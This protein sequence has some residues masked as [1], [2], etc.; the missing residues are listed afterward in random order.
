MSQ[1]ADKPTREQI[2][3]EPAGPR[4]DGWVQEF[5]FHTELNKDKALDYARDWWRRQ[6]RCVDFGFYFSAPFT[7]SKQKP[8]ETFAWRLRPY[9][10]DPAASFGPLLDCMTGKGWL[11]EVGDQGKGPHARFYSASKGV[12]YRAKGDTLSHALARASLLAEMEK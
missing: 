1:P 11:Y 3:T 12:F 10:T 4:L 9:S 8:E 7:A 6:P 2:L 5:V